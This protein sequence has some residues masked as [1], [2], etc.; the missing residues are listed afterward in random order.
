MYFDPS[1]RFSEMQNAQ[2][3]SP[4]VLFHFLNVRF[5]LEN[6]RERK[7]FFADLFKSESSACK[8]VS[9]IFCTDDELLNMNRIHLA[10]DY[11]TD[12]I[13]FNLAVRSKPIEGEIYIS[14]DSVRANA[15]RFETTFPKELQRVMIHGC[16]HLCGYGDKNR[17]QS[18]LMRKKE[19]FYLARAHRFTWNA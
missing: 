18:A 12:V 2:P 7:A 17:S 19:D 16:L 9:F 10:H 4:V 6:R 14:I 13:T 15:V 3:V 8:S 11:Y 1:L 5:A